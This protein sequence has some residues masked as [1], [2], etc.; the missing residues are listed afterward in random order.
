M[1]GNKFG[2]AHGCFSFFGRNLDANR[3]CLRCRFLHLFFSCPSL[4]FDGYNL[5]VFI[6]AFAQCKQKHPQV[7]VSECFV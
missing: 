6:V 7:G 3:Q 2:D 5:H 4:Y 1:F